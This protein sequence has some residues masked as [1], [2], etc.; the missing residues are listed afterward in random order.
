MAA[1][2]GGAFW[3]VKGGVTML[4][5]PEPDLFVFAQLFFALGL[6]GLHAWLAGREGLPGRIGGLLAYVA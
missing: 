5:G 2:L 3:V 4:G 6:L 1:M